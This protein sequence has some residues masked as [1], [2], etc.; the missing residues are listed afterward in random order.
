MAR[1]S[2][3]V[4]QSICHRPVLR[5]VLLYSLKLIDLRCLWLDRI[6]ICERQMIR[7]TMFE[8]RRLLSEPASRRRDT[9]DEWYSEN[10]FQ[11]VLSL[12]HAYDGSQQRLRIQKRKWTAVVPASI[13]QWID[14]LSVLQKKVWVNAI[15]WNLV[16]VAKEWWICWNFSEE[17]EDSHVSLD[18]SNLGNALDSWTTWEEITPFWTT[19]YILIRNTSHCPNRWIYSAMTSIHFK[20]WRLRRIAFNLEHVLFS[21]S[22]F[23]LVRLSEMAG[24]CVESS[25]EVDEEDGDAFNT[26]GIP[27]SSRE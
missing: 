1:R 15:T 25:L 9:S 24:F 3:Q 21:T 19:A 17:R 18:K 13:E 23:G 27:V 26:N 14:H 11:A 12:I 7:W 4:E 6:L 5:R 10:E 16:R 20:A 2:Q 8:P 22:C